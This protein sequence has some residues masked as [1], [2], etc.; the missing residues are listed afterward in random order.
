[1]ART[2]SSSIVPGAVSLRT[3]SGGW[4]AKSYPPGYVLAG[5][6]VCSD[7][8]DC[9]PAEYPTVFYPND[10]GQ[11]AQVLADDGSDDPGSY[12]TAPCPGVGVAITPDLPLSNQGGGGQGGAGQ[13][14]VGDAGGDTTGGDPTFTNNGPGQ[15]LGDVAV[16]DPQ[17]RFDTRYLRVGNDSKEKVT[18]SLQYKTDTADG[19][20][21]F[22]AD[23]AADPNQAVQ[24][25]LAPGEVADIKE[26]DWR[27]NASNVRIWAKSDTQEW[28]MFKDK[29]LPLVPETDDKGANTYA[30]NDLQVFNW[31]VH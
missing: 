5:G 29:D 19:P 13:G 17:G 31:T 22:P 20:K 12:A 9:I 8:V 15:V 6:G 28:N 26:G 7:G 18:V 14:G 2:Y 21:W 4:V 3:C 11:F 30:A 27:L 16:D 24:I 1:M 23:P 10:P 25:T